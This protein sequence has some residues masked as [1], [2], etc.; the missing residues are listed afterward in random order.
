VDAGETKRGGDC[1]DML[2]YVEAFDSI[3]STLNSGDGQ[4]AH[5][6]LA[7]QVA[8]AVDLLTQMREEIR[9]H[10]AMVLKPYVTNK[11][12]LIQHNGELVGEFKI[13]PLIQHYNK[14]LGELGLNLPELMATPRAI[15]KDSTEKE[16][17]DKLVDLFSGLSDKFGTRKRKTFDENGKEVA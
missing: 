5:G 6:L 4:Y 13:N 2:V 15:A 14:L 16:N 12:E 7:S 1:K 9:K 17:G 3:I 8:G 10:G 11:G